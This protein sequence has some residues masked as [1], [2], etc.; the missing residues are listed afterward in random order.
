[1]VA[2]GPHALLN[3]A[4]Y[5]VAL[6][7]KSLLDENPT[8]RVLSLVVVVQRVTGRSADWMMRVVARPIVA[9]MLMLSASLATAEGQSVLYDML[10]NGSSFRVRAGAA[11]TLGRSADPRHAIALEQALHDQ[12]AAVRAAAAHALGDVGATRSLSALQLAANDP[13]QLV[14]E[15]ARGSIAS[16]R[17]RRPPTRA[18]AAKETSVPRSTSKPLAAR[19][20]VVVGSVDNSSGF[21][22]DDARAPLRRALAQALRGQAGVVVID[23]LHAGS[24]LVNVR[25]QHLPI[26]RMDA[27]LLSVKRTEVG[28]RLVVRCEVTLIL[29]DEGERTLRS[30]LRGAA[31]TVAAPHGPRASQERMMAR[32][33]LSNAVKSALNNAS[34]ALS[35]A[36]ERASRP[37]IPTQSVY[38]VR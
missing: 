25:K 31:S 33:A 27:N 12:N 7:F 24:S 28:G 14:S 16:I 15:Q 26:L 22:G 20:A 36:A 11:V 34:D 8:Q 4:T 23:S 37:A 35:D 9:L 29:L 10:R 2:R 13:N 32:A 5:K 3:A 6:N 17:L 38:A 30:V 19:L 18:L 1:M 21:L